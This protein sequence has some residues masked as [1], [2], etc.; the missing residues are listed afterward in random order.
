ML[1]DFPNYGVKVEVSEGVYEPSEDTFLLLEAALKHCSGLAGGVQRGSKGK[2]LEVGIGSGLIACALAKKMSLDVEGVDVDS[3][4][5][6]VAKKNAELNNLIID[7]YES[8]IFS[9]VGGKYN[10]V[11]FNPPYVASE[12]SREEGGS[13]KALDGGVKGREL[14]DRFLEGVGERLEKSGFALML[15][16]SLNG[17]AGTNKV[18][19]EQGLSAEVV[20]REG[21]FFEE[22]VVFKISKILPGNRTQ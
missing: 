22:L 21:L 18:A 12:G 9:N 11:I 4:A 16:S 7:F 3:R 6:K 10:Y 8:D 19:E 5:L 14:I 20:A 13:V 1:V 15:Q 2:L 17:I